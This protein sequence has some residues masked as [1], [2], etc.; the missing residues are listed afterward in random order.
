MCR[1]LAGRAAEDD[2][3][4]VAQDARWGVHKF[5]SV[6]GLRFHY[7]EAGDPTKPLLL[8]LH[9]F[10]E[11]WFSWRWF[12]VAF[13][14]THHVVAVDQRGYGLSDC[15]SGSWFGSPSYSVLNLATDAVCLVEALGHK[16]ATVVAHDWGVV[17][18]WAVAGLLERAGRLRGLCVIN[19]PH[20]GSYH[21]LAGFKQYMRSLYIAVFQVPLLAEAWLSLGEGA[22][23]DHMF[24]SRGMGI[25]RREDPL[26]LTKEDAEVFKWGMRR[27]GRLTAALNWYRN[28]PGTSGAEFRE[29][30]PSPARPLLAPCLVVWGQQDKALGEELI[31]DTASYAKSLKIVRIARC[32]HWAQQDA[33]EEVVQAVAAWLGTK[34]QSL[35]VKK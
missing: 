11:S 12:L 14:A 6:N 22:M 7:V 24:F 28:L 20:L 34:P 31:E 29:L 27:P 15:P 13:K 4:A 23:L 2:P 30:A 21:A 35:T 18:A 3:P 8:C 32:S 10:P 9:G 1:C 5:I 25:Q 17:V 16:D 33:V 26:A 19:G